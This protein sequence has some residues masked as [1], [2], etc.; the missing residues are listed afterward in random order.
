MYL[1]INQHCL[2]KF[3]FKKRKKKIHLKDIMTENF[4]NLVK[5]R[6][7]KKTPGIAESLKKVEP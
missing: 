3:N 7:F 5:E 4:S 2:N 1:F 6:D